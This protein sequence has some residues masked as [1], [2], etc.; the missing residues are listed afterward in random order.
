MAIWDNH[1]TEGECCSERRKISKRIR[2]LEDKA[3][4]IRKKM[5][6][7]EKVLRHLKGLETKITKLEAYGC[8]ELTSIKNRLSEIEIHKEES[9]KEIIEF[10]NKKFLEINKKITGARR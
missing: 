1:I 5:S 7:L 2:D 10:L 3:L 4:A 9:M 6:E 8:D